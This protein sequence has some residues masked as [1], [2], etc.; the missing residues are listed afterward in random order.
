MVFKLNIIFHSQNILK[1]VTL[2]QIIVLVLSIF[3]YV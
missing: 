3:A 2:L 1:Q